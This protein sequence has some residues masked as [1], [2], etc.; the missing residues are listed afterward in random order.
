MN[1]IDFFF[2]YSKSS[3]APF[4]LNKNEHIS[5]EELYNR[6]NQFASFLLEC[7]GTGNNIILIGTN[8]LFFIV[9]YLGIIKSG[10][11]CVPINPSASDDTIG[12]IF[13]E[14]EPRLVLAQK[15]F[16]KNLD[17]KAFEIIEE[18][19][20]AEKIKKYNGELPFQ[21]NSFEENNLAEIIYTSGST[22]FPKGVMISHKNLIANTL[23]I[24]EYLGLSQNDKVLIVLPFYYCYGLSLLHTHL[25]VGGA[26]ALNNTFML[27][28]SVI[29]D[30]IKYE[31]TGFSGV[32][33]HFQILL[34]KS[35]SFK[36]TKFYYLRYVTQAGGKLHQVF[37]DEFREH[38]PNVLFY[39]MYGQTEATARLSYLPPDKINNKPNSIG[40]AIPGVEL[41]LVDNDGK[42]I[43]SD[44]TGEIIAKGNNI[45][46][47]YYKA[48]ELNKKTFFNGYLK[49]GDLAKKDKDGYFYL[50][51][52]KKEII[53]VGG[54]RVSPKE[55]EGIIVSLS[56][57]VDCT[58]EGVYDEVL[59]EKIKATIVTNENADIETLEKDIILLCKNKLSPI[60]VPQIIVFEKQVKINSAGKKTKI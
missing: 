14:T 51:A 39:V 50:V 35:D 2:E 44:E 16:L 5:H 12:Y 48:E 58:I 6:T 33:S 53:K 26:I 4:V 8:S 36:K 52:R 31:C 49:T 54:E 3:K 21:V 7:Y 19:A 25:R 38:F 11:I 28:G 30:L 37:I 32:P 59:G 1:A 10:N 29:N 15:K 27:L 17:E 41:K 23:S 24:I 40:I 45:M 60:K 55:I 43:L 20:V 47:G 57:V 22:A 46:L 42:E 34:R 18:S 9:S 13:K 56:E